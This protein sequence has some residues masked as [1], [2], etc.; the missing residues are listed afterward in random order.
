MDEACTTSSN[1]QMPEVSFDKLKKIFDDYEEWSK[2][3]G[4]DLV[5]YRTY[6]FIERGQYYILDTK[7]SKYPIGT[8]TPY[9]YV[10]CHPDDLAQVKFDTSFIRHP[11]CDSVGS[12]F[13]REFIDGI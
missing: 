6:D 2:E 7:Y 13:D 5:E 11:C 3:L 12:I 8:D 4:R 10:I 9:Y 1:K